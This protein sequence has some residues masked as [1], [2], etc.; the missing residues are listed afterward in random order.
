[1]RAMI[2]V[3]CAAALAACSL[4]PSARP[5]SFVAPAQYA[6][7]GQWQLAEPA[8]E[9]PKGDWW[10]RFD[11]VT[12]DQMQ[13]ALPAGNTSLKAAVARLEQARA[14]ARAAEGSLWP[15]VGLSVSHTKARTSVNAPTYSASRANPVSDYVAT[16]MLSYEVDLFG[17]VR[18]NTQSATALAQAAA[19]D[20][21]VVELNVRAELTND[22]FQIRAIDSQLEVLRHTIQADERA[23][24]LVEHLYQGGAATTSDL[25]QARTQL[26]NA[27]TQVAETLIRRSQTEHA[28]AILLGH[29]P[30]EWHFE[31]NPLPLTLKLPSVFAGQ[32]SALLQR[33]PDIAAAERRVESARAG[34]GIARSAYFPVFS[35][36]AA[37][38]RESTQPSH[39]F[40]APARFWSIAPAATITLLDVGQ[41]RARVKGAVAYLDEA[42]QNY[43]RIVLTA[44]QEVEDQLAA[45]HGLTEA[46]D[47][48]Q[49]SVE[50][51]RIT[52][53]QALHRFEAGATTYLEV[54]V[55]QNALLTA[56]L[57]AISIE[58]RRIAATTL[59]IRALGG[60]WSSPT[61]E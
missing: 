8:D 27:R 61:H 39:W 24:A 19:S 41:R 46:Y 11:D 28:L 13:A 37:L 45:V 60:N 48:A 15:T 42:T 17:R 33:R 21:L 55:A 22:Y 31:A 54:T 25:A 18:A 49:Q 14:N 50:S 7:A 2:L 29:L 9:S 10:R 23:Y 6:E 20:I 12:L 38:G 30:S 56:R 26:E 1:M 40:E 44:Y 43:R 4:K 16:G 51:A 53:E 36:G 58:Q 35:L 34:V 5:V 32:P 59:L 52:H 57:S 3:T 47:S